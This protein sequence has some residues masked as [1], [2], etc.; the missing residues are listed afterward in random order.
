MDDLFAESHSLTSP[1]NENNTKFNE[2]GSSTPSQDEAILT[3]KGSSTPSQ[4]DAIILTQVQNLSTSERKKSLSSIPG[5]K[6]KLNKMDESSVRKIYYLLFQQK[7]RFKEYDEV[8]NMITNFSAFDY[9][10]GTMKAKVLTDANVWGKSRLIELCKLLSLE[11][12]GSRAELVNGIFSFLNKFESSEKG[13]VKVVEMITESKKQTES[14]KKTSNELTL[15]S[16][17]K[18]G[19]D[20]SI[21]ARLNLL[22]INKMLKSLCFIMTNIKHHQSACKSY[23]IIIIIIIILY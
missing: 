3:Q 7:S 18:L 13:K 8:I 6:K 1:M 22:P 11:E 4:D 16:N 9:D 15:Y 19:D 23:I 5:F 12:N 21:K 14:K 20:E 2:K 17:K 10:T